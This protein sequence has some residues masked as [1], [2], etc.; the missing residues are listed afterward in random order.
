MKYLFG[1]LSLAFLTSCAA[2]GSKTIY[3]SEKTVPLQNLGCTQL[4]EAKDLNRIFLYSDSV[5]FSGLQREYKRNLGDSLMFVDASIN[6]FSPYKPDIISICSRYKLNGLIVSN[7]RF[8][9]L[10]MNHIPAEGWTDSC[11][12]LKLFDSNGNL[13]IHTSHK[14]SIGNS[15]GLQPTTERTINDATAGAL[16]RLLK[17]YHLLKK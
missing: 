4:F 2:L 6:F 10:I 7:L 17:E 5:Y 9:R 14:T 15:Y 13:I 16:N 1:I 8:M 3:K 12:E 11:V